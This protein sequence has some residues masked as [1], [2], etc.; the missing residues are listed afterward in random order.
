MKKKVSHFAP[1]LCIV[2]AYSCTRSQQNDE[3]AQAVN[4]HVS[5]LAL[6]DTLKQTLDTL[7]ATHLQDSV[8][9]WRALLAQ[10]ESSLVE[11]PGMEHEHH[12]HGHK[13]EHHQSVDLT[14]AEML[15]VQG[16]L[17]FQIQQLQKRINAQLP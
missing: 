5:A 17:K 3:L 2:L 9:T 7:R 14:P 8:S 12:A 11:V 16:E 4:V 13:H 6:A 15:E 1:L 10:W